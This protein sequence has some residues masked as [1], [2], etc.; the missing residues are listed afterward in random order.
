MTSRLLS[1]FGYQIEKQKSLDHFIF[2]FYIPELNL[3]LDIRLNEIIPSDIKLKK[4][5][6]EIKNMKY[7]IVERMDKLGIIPKTFGMYLK[8]LIDSST[9][10]S[11]T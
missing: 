6:C 9:K 7:V 5:Y 11:T 10:T 1:D 8:N 3:Y 4:Q 2:D